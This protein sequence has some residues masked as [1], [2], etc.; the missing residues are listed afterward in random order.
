MGEHKHKIYSIIVKFP[1]IHFR[2]IQRKTG[3]ATGSLSYNLEVLEKAKKITV[4]R[5]G[6]KKV[7][8]AENFTKDE[9]EIFLALNSKNMRRILL[10]LLTTNYMTHNEIV[11]KMNLS[12][13]TVSWYLKKLRE[14]NLVKKEGNRY[15]LLKRNK[16]KKII[17]TYRESFVDSLIEE[18]VEMWD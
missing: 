17:K 8:F 18:F 12:P 16:L 15:V 7:Y 4:E 14:L 11:Q 9:K 10:L 6:K 1:G 5:V 13:S 3:I 2:E